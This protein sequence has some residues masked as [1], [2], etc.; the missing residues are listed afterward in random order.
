MHTDPTVPRSFQGNGLYKIKY[1]EKRDVL[2]STAECVGVD[3]EIP[4]MYQ[5]MS[6]HTLF[7]IVRHGRASHT[8]TC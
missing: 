2:V 8:Y 7:K 6:E 3:A 4:A 1:N 5:R